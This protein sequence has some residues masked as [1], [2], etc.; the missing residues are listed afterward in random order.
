[1][2][3]HSFKTVYWGDD[4]ST[5]V[6]FEPISELPPQE[7]ITACMVFALHDKDNIVLSKP[8]RGWGLPGGHR[9]EGETAEECLLREA[10]EEAAMTLENIQL[11]GRWATKKLFQSSHNAAY[12]DQGYQLLYVADVKELSE[13]TPQLEITERAVVPISQVKDYHHDYNNLQP[14]FEYV[15]DSFIL[16]T[17]RSSIA[18]R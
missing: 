10:M 2:K 6:V 13:F 17:G 3:M 18:K 7:L 4:Q 15:I 9:E 12:P 8:E 11:V 14:V 1:M 16:R 5:E